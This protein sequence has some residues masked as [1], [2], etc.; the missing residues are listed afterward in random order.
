MFDGENCDI[1]IT[2]DR[3]ELGETLLVKTHQLPEVDVLIAGH[4]GSK[5]STGKLLLDTVKPDTVII[6]AGADNPYGHPAPE[7]LDRLLAY[8]IRVFR[9]DLNGTVIFRR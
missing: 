7:L 1:L 6:S 3:G 2:G 4:H 5:Y 8:G 9:T